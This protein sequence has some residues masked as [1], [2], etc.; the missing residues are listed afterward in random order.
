M[1]RSLGV[2][3]RA[4]APAVRPS[5]SVGIRGFATPKEVEQPVRNIVAAEVATDSSK[6]RQIWI[7]STSLVNMSK[8][9][10]A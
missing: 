7:E 1:H 8:L 10:F 5:A 2:L 9:M 6:V 4:S 3:A